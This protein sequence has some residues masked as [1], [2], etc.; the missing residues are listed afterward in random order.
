MKS[1][2]VAVHNPIAAKAT[3]SNWKLQELID[4]AVQSLLAEYKSNG[5]VKSASTLFGKDGS[6]LTLTLE[7]SFAE[8]S[9]N[10]ALFKFW[11]IFR[12]TRWTGFS[13]I[14]VSAVLDQHV[15]VAVHVDR[16][17]A[18]VIFVLDDVNKE[19]ALV[20]RMNVPFG[21]AGIDLARPTKW[22]GRTTTVPV[23]NLFTDP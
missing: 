2:R 19:L 1:A 21:D 18:L 13:T 10:T 15:C 6:R 3:Q 17:E 8:N 11:E 16:K 12:I 4:E 23:Y 5:Q 7:D 14:R 22:Q 9:P 20:T